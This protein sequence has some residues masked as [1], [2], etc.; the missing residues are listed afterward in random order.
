MNTIR[1]NNFISLKK[2]MKLGK[3]K[4]KKLAEEYQLHDLEIILLYK[5][6][7]FGSNFFMRN[8]TIFS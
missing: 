6:R 2:I 1:R 4:F 5:Y 8:H 3:I 7:S